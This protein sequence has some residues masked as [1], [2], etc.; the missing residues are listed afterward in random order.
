MSKY[1][2]KPFARDGL[3]T[4]PIKSRKSKVQIADFAEAFSPDRS[5]SRFVESLPN[6]LAGKD[7][8]DFLQLMEKAKIRQKTTIFALGA[9]VMKVGLNPLILKLMEEGWITALAMN[10][11]GIIHD[12]E[13]ALAGHTS[14]DVA[15]QI[16]EG[17]FGMAEETGELLNNA[18]N[19]AKENELGLGEAVGEFIENSDFAHKDL[20]ILAVAYKLN[21]PTTVHVA[22]GTDIIHFHQKADGEA[23]G[24]ASMRDFFLFCSLCENLEGGGIFINIGSAVILPEIFLKAVT[25]VRN[26]G[27][28]LED[29]STAVFDFHH[30][31]RPFE[32]V[33][34][35][36][37]GKKGRGFYF[38][39]HHEIMIPLLASSLRSFSPHKD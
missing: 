19:S 7:F 24:N 28:A 37:L 2:F 13:I 39:G 29:F 6:I 3:K 10:G 26:R 23:L 20:S 34:K 1:K 31:Y 18:I 16:K 33:V 35:R 9:H 38:I 4:Y 11:A 25:Y 15:T 8:K 21:I 22:I 17:R 5:F 30:Q 36:P 32:N 14:E 12:F 27:V